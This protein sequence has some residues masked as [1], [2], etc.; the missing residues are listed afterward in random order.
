MF[1]MRDAASRV[2][3]W[4]HI[5]VR[6]GPVWLAGGGRMQGGALTAGTCRLFG[7]RLRTG[8]CGASSAAG[9]L[10]H[11]AR[12]TQADLLQLAQPGLPVAAKLELHRSMM[13][14]YALLQ[15]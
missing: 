13:R 6:R 1:R 4:P 7:C 10:S 12:G 11:G 9:R 5:K 3:E 14:N 2:S 15:A 8:L